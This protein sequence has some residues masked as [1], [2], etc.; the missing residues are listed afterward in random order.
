MKTKLSCPC[1][2]WI[3]GVD[4]DDLVA[5]T[6]AHLAAAHPDLDYSRDEILF[7]AY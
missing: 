6:Q 3:E 4:E 1:G 7:L 2:E 5:R